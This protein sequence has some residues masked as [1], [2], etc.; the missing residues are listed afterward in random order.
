MHMSKDETVIVALLPLARRSLAQLMRSRCCCDGDVSRFLGR[1]HKSS[2]VSPAAKALA[3]P[4]YLTT[5]PTLYLVAFTHNTL[6][7]PNVSGSL[8]ASILRSVSVF[9]EGERTRLVCCGAVSRAAVGAI[10]L[11]MRSTR[12]FSFVLWQG[13]SRVYI[14]R[15]YCSFRAKR[16]CSR[17][18]FCALGTAIWSASL[19]VS[20]V[21]PTTT[22]H[23]RK[24]Y[25]L[26]RNDCNYARPNWY[27]LLLPRRVEDMGWAECRLTLYMPRTALPFPNPLLYPTIR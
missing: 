20:L 15:L 18:P 5:T 11:A 25:T 24:Q 6:R 19:T 1:G 22:K 17:M 2:S 26:R 3:P 4:F 8:V 13:Q 14:L 9:Y 12:C 21:D 23:S 7:C 27:V 16:T 10:A